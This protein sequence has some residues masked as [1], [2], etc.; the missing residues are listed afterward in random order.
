VCGL[1]W[2][3]ALET[4]L[5][6]EVWT[7]DAYAPIMDAWLALPQPPTA[8]VLPNDG[9][10]AMMVHLIRSRGLRVPEEISVIGFDDI[11]DAEHLAG[12][13][14]TI[15]QPFREIGHQ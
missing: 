12:G 10:A 9:L 11:P 8:V 5:D 13:L 3:A 14:T 1:A 15:H 7:P 6:R 2:D 4:T